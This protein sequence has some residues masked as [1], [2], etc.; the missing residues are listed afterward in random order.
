M[1]YKTLYW[2][3]FIPLLI[4]LVYLAYT[5]I[6]RESDTHLTN[7]T[8]MN[9]ENF[10]QMTPRDFK[11][12]LEKQDAI[13]IDVR[14]PEEQEKYGIISDDQIHIEYGRPDFEENLL[15]LDPTKK[16]LVYCW[17]WVRSAATRDIMQANWFSWVNDLKGGIDEWVY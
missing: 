14:T 8:T 11:N 6:I 2:I 15:Q 13:L 3:I 1:N 7:T 9:E 5:H 17:H 12:V 16:Y 4:L 10:S